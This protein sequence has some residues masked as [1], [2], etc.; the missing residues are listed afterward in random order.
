VPILEK[1][2]DGPGSLPLRLDGEVPNLGRFHACRRVA[3]TIYLGSA[4]TPTAANRGLE[5]RR[6]KLGCV[7]PGESPAVFGDALL[8]T[9]FAGTR[10]RLEL[11]RVPLWRGDHVAIKQLAE[12][13]ARYLYL[14]RLKEPAVL[15]QAARDGVGLLTWQQ[16]SFAYAE[17][18]DEAAGR[19]RG[20]QAGRQITVVM[21]GQSLLVKP[22]VAARLLAEDERQAREARGE[23]REEEPTKEAGKEEA[24]PE[25]PKEPARPRRFHGSVNVD[26][27]RLARDAG[28]IAQEV[29]QHLTGLVGAK[30]EISLEIQAVIP[31]GAPDQ[32]VRTVTENCR[33]LKFTTHGF[34]QS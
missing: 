19:Y 8:V 30:V 31:E 23:R 27:T 4:P 32:V 22:D 17:S 15:L 1:D 26:P 6:V 29:V 18:W 5:D 24:R 16:D 33:T 2:V 7:M 10:L 20:L 25:P 14:P 21:D 34:E 3:R 9:T 11:D 28:Q 13:F 12:D